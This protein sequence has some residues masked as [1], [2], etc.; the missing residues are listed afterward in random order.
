MTD[1]IGGIGLLIPRHVPFVA[2]HTPSSDS[3]QLR[4]TSS[5]DIYYPQSPPDTRTS[6]LKTVEKFFRLSKTIDN[7]SSAFNHGNNLSIHISKSNRHFFK[8]NSSSHLSHSQPIVTENPR[9][10][11]PLI[12]HSEQTPLIERRN[13][14]NHPKTSLHHTKHISLNRKELHLPLDTD[15]LHRSRSYADGIITASN[16]QEIDLTNLPTTPLILSLQP[17]NSD[18]TSLRSSNSTVSS[19]SGYIS[20]Q[21]PLS[22]QQINGNPK[23]DINK[24]QESIFSFSS[25]VH[26]QRS[27]KS[28]IMAAAAKDKSTKQDN[29]VLLLIRS[30]ALRSPEDFQGK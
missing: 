1:T 16:N 9:C 17:N 28:L 23:H 7:M 3:S 13:E 4:R 14:N 20:T 24:S 30:W 26:K 22:T 10:D 27:I 11:S 5:S 25:P 15:C 6:V 18:A 29:D 21:Q 8:L 12:N 19:L 2:V